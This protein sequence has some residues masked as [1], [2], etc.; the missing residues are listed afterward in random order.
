[1]EETWRKKISEANEAIFCCNYPD[2]CSQSVLHAVEATCLSNKAQPV[3][4]SIQPTCCRELIFTEPDIILSPQMDYPDRIVIILQK[5]KLYSEHFTVKLKALGV[6]LQNEVDVTPELFQYC[7]AFTLRH[8]LAPLWNKI[9]DFMVQEFFSEKVKVFLKTEESAMQYVSNSFVIIE[10]FFV[11]PNMLKAFQANDNC[12]IQDT[13]IDNN[14]CYVIPSMKEAFVCSISRLL[15]KTSPF[16]SYEELRKHWK[17]MYGYHLPTNSCDCYYNVRFYGET[18]FTSNEPVFFYRCDSESIQSTF[19]KDLNLRVPSIC[20]IP[21]TLSRAP[22]RQEIRLC[23]AIADSE[24]FLQRKPSPKTTALKALPTSFVNH[25]VLGPTSDAKQIS[26]VNDTVKSLVPVSE[27]KPRLVPSFTKRRYPMAIKT[28]TF[29]NSKVQKIRKTAPVVVAA[30][31]IDQS[32]K[33]ST[34]QVNPKLSVS[35]MLGNS[36]V[37]VDRPRT[38]PSAS[39]SGRIAVASSVI[40]ANNRHTAAK[41]CRATASFEKPKSLPLNLASQQTVGPSTKQQ[42]G[43]QST[44]EFVGKPPR[45]IAPPPPLLERQGSSLGLS[46]AYQILQDCSHDDVDDDDFEEQPVFAGKRQQLMPQATPCKLAKS[47]SLQFATEPI[48]IPVDLLGSVDPQKRFTNFS[49]IPKSKS[50]NIQ[51]QARKS[52]SKPVADANL[53]MKELVRRNELKKANVASLKAWLKEKGVAF[54]ANS[55][56]EDLTQLVQNYVTCHAVEE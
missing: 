47:S 56:K 45:E 3:E 43:Q 39:L 55:K 49:Q 12:V 34:E 16:T 30:K 31:T 38:T 28:N 26:S 51:K 36:S 7:L 50:S 15:P 4:T 32:V 29:D 22:L 48:K 53:D 11:A 2:I 24:S 17:L 25:D 13:S 27:T 52:R 19:L 54:K 21:I 44:E 35:K 5:E 6:E 42:I 20:G 23:K 8:R 14:R 33:K 18:M 10:D 1:M 41:P 40:K 9:G 37:P 46:L